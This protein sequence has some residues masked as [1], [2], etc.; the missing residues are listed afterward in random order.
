MDN[1]IR[2]RNERGTARSNYTRWL[3]NRF[4]SIELMTTK[5]GQDRVALS[6][7]YVPLRLGREDID[8]KD[9]KDEKA[10]GNDARDTIVDQDFVAVSGRPGSGKTTLTQ[11]LIGELCNESN[12]EFRHNL[13]SKSKEN[14]QLAPLPVPLILRDF[15]SQLSTINSFDELLNAWWQM[16]VDEAINKNHPPFYVQQ[17]AD[18]VAKNGDN[19]RL[20][21]IF[22]GID[23]VGGLDAR[24]HVV[25][26]AIEAYNQGHKVIITGR[27]TGYQD[28]NWQDNR[29][30]KVNRTKPIELSQCIYYVQPFSR[31]QIEAFIRR[32]YRIMDTWQSKADQ[33]ITQFINAIS[34]T[35]RNYLLSLARRPIFL[36]LMS[37][38][39]VN[40]TQM[41]DGRADLYKRI[42]DLYLIRQTQH[43]QLKVTV[44]DVE[45]HKWDETEIRRALGY[46]AW[47][48][49]N[50]IEDE[51]KRQVVWSLSLIHI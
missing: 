17:M 24:L 12:S 1:S 15:Q 18:S 45:L 35:Q 13:A 39:H 19:R 29:L 27:P 44:K 50:S 4:G 41:P 6:K 40:D 9:V 14:E 32:F 7:I 8:E 2:A 33:G 48:S 22:D 26:L 28:I 10:L 51:E 25:K 49:Q 34:D 3:A 21:V 47:F 37:L 46:L 11:A 30:Q 42:I 31:K 43:K 23:E 5:D 20:L 38:V 36:T 16:A